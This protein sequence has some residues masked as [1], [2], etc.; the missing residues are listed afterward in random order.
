MTGGCHRVG[1]A[2]VAIERVMGA[3]LTHADDE[4]SVEEPLEIRLAYPEKGQ[5]VERSVSITMRT[6][7]DDLALAAGF[8]ATEGLL[9]RRE[10]LVSLRHCGPKTGRSRNV[11]RLELAPNAPLDLERLDRHFYTTSSCGVCGKSSLDALKVAGQARLAPG[12]ALDPA[13]VPTLGDRLREAQAVFDRT[14]G[15]HAAAINS[16]VDCWGARLQR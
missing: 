5:I 10:D 3:S 12:P 7:G 9:R 6:P 8:L 14:G 11:V 4:L 15:L 13:V 2:S 16:D 1:V